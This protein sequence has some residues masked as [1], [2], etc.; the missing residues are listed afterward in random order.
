MPDLALVDTHVHLWDTGNLRY[1][2]LE[3]IPRLNRPFLPA[4]FREHG[5]DVAVEK[6][7]FVECD[8]DPAQY[9]EEAAWAASLVA[10]EPRIGGIVAHAPLQ[11]GDRA[12]AALERLSEIPLVRGIRRLIQAEPDPRFCLRPDFVRGVQLLARF[13][14]SFDICVYHPQLP[15]VVE[16][17]QRCPDVAFVLDH[18]GKPGIGEG[19]LDPWRQHISALARRENVWCK[20]SGLVTE[21]DREHWTRRDLWPYIDHVIDRFGFRRVMYGGDWP[22]SLLAC[23]YPQWVAALDWAV[24]GAS[25]SERRSLYHDNASIFYRL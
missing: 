18:I 20:L 4:D 10:E 2:W 9:H 1:P 13:G 6:I 22:V 14:F 11:Q 12:Q 24:N 25:E 17:V 8:V 3:G 19:R 15:S 16:L 21:A 7:V 23:R 5:E